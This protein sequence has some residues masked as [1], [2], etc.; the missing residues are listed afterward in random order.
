[1]FG[2]LRKNI[3]ISAEESV[4]Y[5]ELKKC[6]PCFDKQYSELLD[7]RKQAKQQCLQDLNKING[8]NVNNIT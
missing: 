2:K 6:K 8:D 4:G 7:I 5:Y 1:V 3:T